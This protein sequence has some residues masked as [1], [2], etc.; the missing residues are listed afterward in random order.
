MQLAS[1]KVYSRR[2]INAVL[3]VLVGIACLFAGVGAGVITMQAFESDMSPRVILLGSFVTIGATVLGGS[4]LLET[5][6]GHPK[7]RLLENRIEIVRLWGGQFAMWTSLA[8]FE[9]WDDVHGKVAAAV[10]GNETDT[11]TKI[12]KRFMFSIKPNNCTVDDILQELNSFR[13]RAILAES[14]KS[15]FVEIHDNDT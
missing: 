11:E 14:R 10:V 3:A 5:L 4:L 15:G 13:N 2:F 12:A 7:L 1:E 9:I 8:R 6:T